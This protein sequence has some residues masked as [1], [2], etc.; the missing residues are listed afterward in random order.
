MFYCNCTFTV[1]TI[2][3][4]V[5]FRFENRIS[6]LFCRDSNLTIMVL[7]PCLRRLCFHRC[8]CPQGECLP[9]PGQIPPPPGRHPPAQ[10]VLG[11]GQQVG[12]MHPTGMHSCFFFCFLFFLSLFGAVVCAV[13]SKLLTKITCFVIH[14]CTEKGKCNVWVVLHTELIYAVS[15]RYSWRTIDFYPVLIFAKTGQL[16]T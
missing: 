5:L 16:S 13:T 7:G 2:R 8:L 4:G 1:L 9:P 6:R 14:M 3:V 15:H 12:G 11:Y 10:C